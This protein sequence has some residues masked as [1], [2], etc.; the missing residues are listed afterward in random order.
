MKSLLSTEASTTMPKV[1]LRKQIKV[2][3]DKKVKNENAD[4][5]KKNRSLWN[6]VRIGFS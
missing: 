5:Q 6:K 3:T 1:I 2:K 4:W